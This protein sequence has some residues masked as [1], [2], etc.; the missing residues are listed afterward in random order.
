VY[1][2]FDDKDIGI[3]AMGYREKGV[4]AFQDKSADEQKSGS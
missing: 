1:P 2:P 4:N 3:N